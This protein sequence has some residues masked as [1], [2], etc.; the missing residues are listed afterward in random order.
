MHHGIVGLHGSILLRAISV[1]RAAARNALRDSGSTL[2]NIIVQLPV[3]NNIA[4]LPGIAMDRVSNIF[5]SRLYNS[6]TI[7]FGRGLFTFAS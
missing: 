4:D 2:V 7:I 5:C 3:S 6:P 1:E